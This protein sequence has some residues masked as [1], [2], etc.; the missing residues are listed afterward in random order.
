[1]AAQG[2]R[3]ESAAWGLT[4]VVRGV[5]QSEPVAVAARISDRDGCVDVR[6]GYRGTLRTA[7]P[8]A[9]VAAFSAAE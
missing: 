7:K 1:M 5:Q 4:G 2:K 8:A 9:A 6:A 3:G